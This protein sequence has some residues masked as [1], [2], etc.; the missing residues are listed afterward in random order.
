MQS[1]VSGNSWCD[2]GKALKDDAEKR[3]TLCVATAL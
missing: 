2:E 1:Q 3:D